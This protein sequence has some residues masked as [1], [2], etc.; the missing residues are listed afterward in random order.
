M[1]LLFADTLFIQLDRHKI[2]IQ[3]KLDKHLI[4]ADLSDMV[5]GI[6]FCFIFSTN[7][8]NDQPGQVESMEYLH[9][10]RAKKPRINQFSY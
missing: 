1:A 4:S 8:V 3:L 2:T 6:Y 10:K 7:L 9:L 5:N